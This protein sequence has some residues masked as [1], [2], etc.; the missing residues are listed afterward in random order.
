[1]KTSPIPDGFHTVTPYLMVERAGPFLEFIEKA[2]GA[3][4]TERILG[5]GGNV[6]HAQAKIGDSMLMLGEANAN[7]KAE[8]AWLYLYVEN[9]DEAHRRALL[10]GATSL[11]EPGDQ[12][13]GDRSSGVRDAW[14]ITWWLATQIE[15]VPPTELQKRADEMMKK[16]S[17]S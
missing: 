16:R 3:T 7:W 4:I 9:V 13:Y 15:V 12:F 1:M 11:M 8:P 5:P 17:A 14:G 6:A 10:A 2:F